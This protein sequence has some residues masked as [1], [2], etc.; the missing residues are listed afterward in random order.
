M[1]ASYI[2][3]LLLLSS[4]SFFLV[5]LVLGA[6]I[7]WIAP[8]VLRRAHGMRPAKA[9]QLL[10]T[11]RLMPAAVSIVAVCALGLPSYLKFEPA[12]TSEQAGALC[13]IAAI[14]GVLFCGTAIFRAGSAIIRSTV[15][16]S[17]QIE[18]IALAGILR[19]RLL[20]SD[21]ARCKLSADQM[22][23]ALRHEDAHR[24]S[25]DNL[26]RLLLLLA[27]AM[28]P[29]QHALERMW[30]RCTEW[31]ADDRAT[32]GDPDRSVALA[33][34]LVCVARLQSRTG[35]PPLVTS[36]I[37]SGEDLSI[38]VDRLLNPVSRNDSRAR[39]GA[40]A[41]YGSAV[42]LAAIGANPGALRV[43]HHLLERLLD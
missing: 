11:V 16:R 32:G 24:R 1:T 4:A 18:G 25:F 3:R 5:Q 26:K 19:P 9:S 20:I 14:L 17:G 12:S 40:L 31:A 43:V 10:F 35:L 8:A 36:L 42:L 15:Y 2:V 6:L 38:R 39:F 27:P 7:A 21:R 30:A 13:L 33:E 22:E 28:F 37:D 34:A 29:R 23:V 41:I